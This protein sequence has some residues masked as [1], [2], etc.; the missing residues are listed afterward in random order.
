MAQAL[1]YTHEK[2]LFNLAS[3]DCRYTKCVGGLTNLTSL[4]FFC[5]TTETPKDPSRTA[6]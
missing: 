2:V 1:G 4:F 5:R 3:L 6:P